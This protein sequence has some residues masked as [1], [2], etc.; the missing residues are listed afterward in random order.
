MPTN[1]LSTLS[2]L[3]IVSV[4]VSLL[5]QLVKQHPT[6]KNNAGWIL[7]VAS[8]VIGTAYFFLEKL[9]S[10][11]L[12]LA[13]IVTIGSYANAFYLLVIQWFEDKAPSGPVNP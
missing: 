4:G 6:L 11:P 8:I 5:V 3:A 9:Q 10:W 7:V 1:I 2:S 13:S 12:I